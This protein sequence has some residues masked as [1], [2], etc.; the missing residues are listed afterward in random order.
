MSIN[1]TSGSLLTALDHCQEV[2]SGDRLEDADH[3]VRSQVG[4]F[5]S[6]THW[7]MSSSMNRLELATDSL[8]VGD[9]L[10]TLS[11]LH[12][13]AQEVHGAPDHSS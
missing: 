5:P 8:R 10:R 7:S 4:A 2:V 3:A 12:A 11:D 9:S 13:D 6:A 1:S